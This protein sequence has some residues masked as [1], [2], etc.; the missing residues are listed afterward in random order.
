MNWNGALGA[1]DEKRPNEFIKRQREG[2]Q[3]RGNNS[4]ADKRKNDP[5]EDEE[6]LCS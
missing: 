1:D 4:W 6:G 3:N 5:S 2:E